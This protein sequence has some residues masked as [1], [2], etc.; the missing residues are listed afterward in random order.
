VTKYSQMHEINNFEEHGTNISFGLVKKQRETTNSQK[1]KLGETNE[2]RVEQSSSP[3]AYL[4]IRNQ[5]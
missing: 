2:T 1:T 4:A 3:G 5:P